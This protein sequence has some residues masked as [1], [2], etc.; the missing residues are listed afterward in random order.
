MRDAVH[1]AVQV[2][3]ACRAE[4]ERGEGEVRGMAAEVA[5]TEEL[6]QQLG[7]S[8]GADLHQ[9]DQR[10]QVRAP[11]GRNAQ[12]YEPREVELAPQPNSPGDEVFLDCCGSQTCR[13]QVL[14][15]SRR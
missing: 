4:K 9:A 2:E 13:V 14:E 15:H 8:T 7:S 12:L 11:A 6:L 1:L 3:G 5:A 10:H